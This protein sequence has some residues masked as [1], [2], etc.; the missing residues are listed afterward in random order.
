MLSPLAQPPSG[1]DFRIP[2]IIS[3]LRLTPMLRSLEI[4][5]SQLLETETLVSSGNRSMVLSLQQEFPGSNCPGRGLAQP[6]HKA[7]VSTAIVHQFPD[8]HRALA[9]YLASVSTLP[10]LV[11]EACRDLVEILAEHRV[12][13]HSKKYQTVLARLVDGLTLKK[14]A[15]VPSLNWFWSLHSKRRALALL[16]MLPYLGMKRQRQHEMY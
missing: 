7:V 6:C 2:I 16:S 11:R 14:A 13:L 1:C 12:S 10:A 15:D 5:Q 3:G 8:I 4:F 9:F